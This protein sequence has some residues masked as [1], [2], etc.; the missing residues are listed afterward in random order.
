MA[1]LRSPVRAHFE[2]G[3]E[4]G[5]VAQRRDLQGVGAERVFSECVSS[6][7]KRPQLEAALD[8]VRE[9]DALAVTKLDRLARPVADLLATPF[10]RSGKNDIA[11]ARAICEAAG[12]RMKKRALR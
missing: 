3:Q 9:G 5:L 6:V 12:A 8:F 10:V 11:D 1:S 7:A 2:V 4:A